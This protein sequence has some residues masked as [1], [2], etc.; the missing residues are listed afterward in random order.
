MNFKGSV[1]GLEEFQKEFSIDDLKEE[2]K[3]GGG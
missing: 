2:Y 1:L 3:I